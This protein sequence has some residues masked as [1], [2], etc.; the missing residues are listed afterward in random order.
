MEFRDRQAI[1]LQIADLL[2]ETI[3][4]GG[5]KPG[6]RI[7]SVR[8]TAEASEVNPNTI[9][10]TYAWMEERGIIRNQ[11]GVGY[12]LAPDAYERVRGLQRE[13]FQ[14]R[15]L[16]RVFRLMDLLRINFDELRQMYKA[17]KETSR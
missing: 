17:Y 1:Y 6:E 4:S 3:L 13:I 14:R 7:P 12:F 10:R 15:E 11:R 5:W 2:C 8:E 9:T 16:P